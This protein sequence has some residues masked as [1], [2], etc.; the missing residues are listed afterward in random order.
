MSAR[1]T[2]APAAPARVYV[3]PTFDRRQREALRA[4][5]KAAHQGV[6]H[7]AN[8]AACSDPLELR[9]GLRCK[10]IDDRAGWVISSPLL[11][12]TLRRNPGLDESRGGTAWLRTV[13]VFQRDLVAMPSARAAVDQRRADSRQVASVCLG[14]APEPAAH[15]PQQLGLFA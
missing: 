13:Y 15:Q 8:A 9:L 2:K 10:R 4:Y 1:R 3:A 6:V 14:P 5:R 11:D 12:D 7:R